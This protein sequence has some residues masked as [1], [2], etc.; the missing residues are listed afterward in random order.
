MPSVLDRRDTTKWSS[1][2]RR[3]K[4]EGFKH[5]DLEQDHDENEHKEHEAPDDDAN[6]DQDKELE[7]RLD[8]GE[9]GRSAAGMWSY[10]DIATGVQC[11]LLLQLKA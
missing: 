9:S 3:G 6:I 2:R 10:Q 7:S 8:R 4:P 11:S 5:E 1:S